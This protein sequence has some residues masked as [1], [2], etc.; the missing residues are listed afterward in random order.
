VTGATT[1]RE[2]WKPLINRHPDGS[3]WFYEHDRAHERGPYPTRAEAWEAFK[4]YIEEEL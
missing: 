3:W 4:R 2:R 1:A